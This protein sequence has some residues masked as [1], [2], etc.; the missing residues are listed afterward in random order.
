MRRNL[1]QDILFK[2][3]NEHMMDIVE[4]FRLGRTSIRT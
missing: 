3:S 2:H 1:V 4:Q